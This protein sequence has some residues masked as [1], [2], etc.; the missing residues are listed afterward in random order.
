MTIIY[1]AYNLYYTPIRIHNSMTTA[2]ISDL[3]KATEN[4]QIY[5]TISAIMYEQ[6]LLNV[7]SYR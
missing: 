4:Q 3:T 6:L 7:H 2:P 1:K 5:W